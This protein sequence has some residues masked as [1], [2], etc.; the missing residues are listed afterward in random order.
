MPIATTVSTPQAMRTAWLDE[1]ESERL[2]DGVAFTRVL[3]ALAPGQRR[4][5]R[6]RFDVCVALHAAADQR[7]LFWHPLAIGDGEFTAFIARAGQPIGLPEYLG[8]DHAVIEAT[9]A[10][11]LRGSAEHAGWLRTSLARH[12]AIEEE[13]LFPADLRAHGNAGWVRGLRNEHEYL[14][15]GLNALDALTEPAARRRFLLLLDGH[16]E[17][18]EQIVYPDMLVRLAADADPLTRAA[19][20]HLVPRVSG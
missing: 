3:T 6:G 4:L 13:L 14:R 9:L 10:G 5:V 18:E 12:L 17:K 8:R 2:D 19:M 15:Q 11:A 16:D 1:V 20:L 7:T